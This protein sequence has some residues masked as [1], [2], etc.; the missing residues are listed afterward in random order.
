M[1]YPYEL[2]VLSFAITSVVFSMESQPF[3]DLH[4]A[5]SIWNEHGSENIAHEDQDQDGKRPQTV[6]GDKF[7]IEDYHS[8]KR[9]QPEPDRYAGTAPE[10][11]GLWKMVDPSQLKCP[12][13]RTIVYRKLLQPV[14]EEYDMRHKKRS[15]L[16]EGVWYSGISNVKNQKQ[17]QTGWAMAATSVLEWHLVESGNSTPT[18]LS[19]QSIIDCVQYGGC[20]VGSAREAFDFACEFG[21]LAEYDYPY[22]CSG[23]KN[24]RK[25]CPDTFPPPRPMRINKGYEC[26]YN[27]K[28]VMRVVSS[29]GPVVAGIYATPK[30]AA[31]RHED[32]DFPV[33]YECPPNSSVNHEVVII[34]YGSETRLGWKWDYWIIKNSQGMDWGYY[35]TAK[36]AR[37]NIFCAMLKNFII[38]VIPTY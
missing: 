14:P 21:I 15:D 10:E 36:V 19:A 4:E 11:K 9:M 17:C 8:Q 18:Y 28:E 16:W 1:I 25:K 24:Y 34:G 6:S 27:D 31:L 26:L 35:G 22:N 13:V 30:F 2:F 37:A 32:S 12:R 33:F 29:Y 7:V 3:E 5:P 20:E 23:C 38:P